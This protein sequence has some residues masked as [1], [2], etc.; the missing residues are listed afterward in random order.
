MALRKT[1]RP[2]TGERSTPNGQ[3]EARWGAKA[4]IATKLNELID[5]R[6]L[7]QA[8]AGGVMGMPQPKV[9]AIRRLKVT[10]I[11]LERLLQ[12]LGA[13]GQQV[14]IVV[15]ASRPGVPPGIRVDA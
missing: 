13:L 2:I 9:S 6:G 12:A 14:D 5:S 3:L 7:S 15:S 8:Q 10:G 11:S 1:P 4:A